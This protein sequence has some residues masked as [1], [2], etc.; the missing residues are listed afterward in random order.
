MV[1]II[2]PAYNQENHIGRAIE[3]ALKQEFA[4]KEIL[5]CDDASTDNTRE[6]AKRYPIKFFMNKENIGLAENL[7]KLISLS[8]GDIIV[9]LCGDDEF[10]NRHVIEDI[11]Y[12]FF[13]NDFLG[14][15]GRYF[16][17]HF[18]DYK[19]VITVHGDILTSSCQ[20]SG[21][22]FRKEAIQGNFQDIRFAEVPS[23]VKKILDTGKWKYT[24]IKYDTVAAL[25]HLDKHPNAAADPVYYDNKSIT[26]TWSKLI[27]KP[28]IYYYGF[29]QMKNRRPDL[30]ISEIL[31][32]IELKPLILIDPLF[33]IFALTAILIPS[34][35]LI[36]L[37]V[38]YRKHITSLFCKEITRR[39]WYA[40]NQYRV[41]KQ[42]KKRR[43]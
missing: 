33:W 32:S 9:I 38:F 41:R 8:T 23:M 19:P 34:S 6:I 21:I 15:C 29:I 22:G 4:D 30:L 12:E 24:Q 25:L 10:T 37:S 5:V 35:I 43:Y 42:R 14:V 20:P 39:E 2:I 11:N 7:N 13:K 36:P 1:S 31:I 18:G 26:M 16:Y 40:R 27:G 3:S 17:Q 28:R